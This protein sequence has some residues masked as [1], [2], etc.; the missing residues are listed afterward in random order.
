[1]APGRKVAARRK[2]PEAVVPTANQTISPS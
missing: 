1:V 2:N